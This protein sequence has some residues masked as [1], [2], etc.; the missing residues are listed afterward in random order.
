[1]TPTS[2]SLIALC[3]TF[4]TGSS[5][6]C[7]LGEVRRGSLTTLSNG[8]RSGAYCGGIEDEAY[9]H[10]DANS[11]DVL[12]YVT[13][14]SLRELLSGRRRVHALCI[15]ECTLRIIHGPSR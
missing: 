2:L 12:F 5:T 6:P 8:D 4:A 11:E 7:R 14:P 10:T 3:Y 13:P 15:G 9:L 1:M